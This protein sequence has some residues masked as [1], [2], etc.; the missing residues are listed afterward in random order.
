[1][2]DLTWLMAVTLLSKFTLYLFPLALCVEE[3]IAPY[4]PTNQVMEL[5]FTTIRFAL[6][7]S[8]LLVGIR[9]PSFASFCSVIGLI[10]TVTISVIFLAA[11]HLKWF[12]P[13][14]KDWEKCVDYLFILGGSTVAIF[15]TIATVGLFNNH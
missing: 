6:I 13:Q 11:S 8:S 10:C 14:L 5:S 4:V 9:L 1:M 12:G 2:Q 3:I 15:G 7:T